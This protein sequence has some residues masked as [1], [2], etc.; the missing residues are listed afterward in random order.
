MTGVNIVK[1]AI[2]ITQPETGNNKRGIQ[3]FTAKA[4][5]RKGLEIIK[6]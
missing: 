6:S 5:R 3:K 1:Q 2:N 4:L